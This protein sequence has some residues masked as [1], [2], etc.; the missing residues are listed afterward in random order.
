MET[1]M[2]SV[3]ISIMYDQEASELAG[4]NTNKYY[5]IYNMLLDKGEKFYWI[6]NTYLDLICWE[7]RCGTNESYQST[8]D[9]K[10]I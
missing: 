6:F 3:G 8:K 9:A 5:D 1:N 10:V 2:L 7:V 4:M